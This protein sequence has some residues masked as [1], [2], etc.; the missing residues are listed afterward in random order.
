MSASFSISNVFIVYDMKWILILIVLFILYTLFDSSGFSRGNKY[1]SAK[2][3]NDFLAADRDGFV[4]SLNPINLFARR[5]NSKEE[6][7]ARISKAGRDFTPEQKEAIDTLTRKLPASKF[8]LV[9]DTYEDGMPH[10]REDIIFIS[11]VPSLST[12]LHERLHVKQRYSPPDLVGMG[13]TLVG[14]RSEYPRARI[15][16]DVNDDVWLSPVTNRPMVALFTSDRPLNLSDINIQP[17]Y[18]HPYE[19]L[20]YTT[21]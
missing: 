2:E 20:A 18:E 1:L 8:A 6:Y 5:S 13:Y 19:Y 17:H 7:L 3:T 14:K 16:P 15:N 10:T 4:A 9:D 12:I 11:S 21:T